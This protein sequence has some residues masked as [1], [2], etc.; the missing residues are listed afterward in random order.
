MIEE[1]MGWEDQPV[2]TWQWW[3]EGIDLVMWLG[4]V[5]V[6]VLVHKLWEKRHPKPVP[7]HQ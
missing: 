2:D 7:A 5:P 3:H 6:A 4:W 1:A